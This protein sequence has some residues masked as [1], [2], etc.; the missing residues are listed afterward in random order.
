MKFGIYPDENFKFW[1]GARA[2]FDKSTNY[3]LEIPY[4]RKSYESKNDN[5][6]EEDKFIYWVNTKFFKW[7]SKQ[8]NKEL[9]FNGQNTVLELKDGKYKAKASCQGSHGYLY[10]GCWEKI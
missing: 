6:K 9:Y 2:I 1:W 4:D 5:K 7:I 8:I 3:K 10:I